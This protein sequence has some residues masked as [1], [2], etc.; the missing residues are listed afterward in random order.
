VSGRR[1]EEGFTHDSVSHDV[2]AAGHDEVGDRLKQSADSLDE[3]VAANPG[4]AFEGAS[5][6]QDA[7]TVMV[8]AIE[9]VKQAFSTFSDT[10]HA[11]A[12][13]IRTQKANR[14]QTESA[15]ENRLNSIRPEADH[16]HV[17]SG[18][19]APSG[20]AAG[21]S[22]S[23]HRALS[24][25]GPTL[26]AE[27]ELPQMDRAAL[28]DGHSFNQEYDSV[29]ASHGLDR[30][31]HDAL[32]LS[33]T[34]NLTDDQ[35]AEVVAVRDNF[36]IRPGQITTKVLSDEVAE[37][38]LSNNRA[39]FG[40]KFDPGS[41]SGFVARGTDVAQLTT[42]DELRYGL[43]LDDSGAATKWSP[44]P[45]GADHAYQMR[46]AADRPG[47]MPIAYGAIPLT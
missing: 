12:D 37:H 29:L 19:T 32:R 36:Q 35:L 9:K 7:A 20:G 41:V 28:A 38:Y 34:R 2:A 8:P 1:E 15:I 22:T 42:P 18:A 25:G 40:G 6:T 26:S 44:I 43:A 33:E 11:D 10:W 45:A 13:K 47:Q 24:G 23:I 17:H 27:Q 21:A 30:S 3:G 16:Q 4:A 39:A 46:W 5:W 14:E 31:A